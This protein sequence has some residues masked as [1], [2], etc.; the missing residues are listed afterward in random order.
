MSQA[1]ILVIDPV[2]PEPDK[3]AYAAALLRAGQ[4][5][6]F[7]TE[8][9]YGL[10]ANALDPAAVE[11]VFA[12]KKRPAHDPMIVHIA[13]WEQL[14]EAAADISPQAERLARAFWPGPLTLILRKTGAIPPNVTAGLDTVAV[15]M[16]A[17]PIAQA[18]IVACGFPIAAPSANLFA[19]PSPTTA[20]HV[21]EDLGER[22]ELVIDGGPTPIGVES[23]VVDTTRQSL[24]LLRPGGISLEALKAIV[25]GL[26]T[27][28]HPA[29]TDETR[30]QRSPGQLS[31]H[32]APRARLVLFNGAEA[33]TLEHMRQQALELLAEGQRVG[34]LIANEDLPA[35]DLPA[36]HIQAIGSKHDLPGVARA[37]FAA[38]RKLD[39]A[40]AD[41]ILARNFGPDGLGLA[42][43]DRLRRAAG[44]NIT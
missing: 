22:I 29:A 31:K 28:P 11:R 9:V 44:G 21:L 10:G 41:V 37:L 16:P 39:S 15:R 3:I 5:V 18:L 35:F 38:L 40:G 30:A 20:A 26:G 36:V 32:Y 2:T 7:P 6:A 42:I 4:P 19:R 8:T 25:P 1:E 13:G 43:Q 12:A 23:S 27:T 17:H 14:L 24:Q 34:V 33:A